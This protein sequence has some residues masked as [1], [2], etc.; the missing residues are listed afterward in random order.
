MLYK[1]L[2]ISDDFPEVRPKYSFTSK[3]SYLGGCVC[4][5]EME[6]PER[7]KRATDREDT[8]SRGFYSS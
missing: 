8:S 4:N 5:P 2:I 1:R 3:A 6:N 7:T